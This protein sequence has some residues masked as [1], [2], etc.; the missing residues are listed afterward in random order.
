[1]NIKKCRERNIVRTRSVEKNLEKIFN[2]SKKAKITAIKQLQIMRKYKI[3]NFKI[4]EKKT[5]I[6]IQK[7]KK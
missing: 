2:T 1:M 6:I 3:N 4:M 7:N 5:L